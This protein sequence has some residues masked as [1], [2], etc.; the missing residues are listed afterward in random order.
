M[1]EN[2][3]AW[4]QLDDD[5]DGESAGDHFGCSVSISSNGHILAVGAHLCD[6]YSSGV[7]NSGQIFWFLDTYRRNCKEGFKHGI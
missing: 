5:I 3:N 7:D 4:N 2:K 6:S 1:S